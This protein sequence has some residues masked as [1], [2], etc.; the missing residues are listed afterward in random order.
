VG[1]QSA[2]LLP[3]CDRMGSLMYLATGAGL[4]FRFLEN[5]FTPSAKRARLSEQKSKHRDRQASWLYL[6]LLL[7]NLPLYGIDRDRRLDQLYHTAW[8]FK[9]GAPGEI[10]ALAQ[11]TDG[12]LWLGTATGLFR[13]DGIRFQRYKP[14]SEQAFP[15]RSVVSL[16]AVPD[17]GLWVGYRQGGVS[18]IKNETVTDYG[19]E[20]G[21]PSRAVLAFARDHQGTIWIAAGKDGL[22]RLDGSRWRKLGEDWGLTGHAYSVFVDHAGTLWVGTPTSVA[23]LVEGGHQFQIAAEHLLPF[24]HSFSEAPDG[25]LWMA[26]GGYGVRPVPLPGKNNGRAGPAVLVGSLAITF[27]NQGSLWITSAGNGIRRVPY[28]EG[29]HPPKIRGAS[30]WMF[31]NSEVEA[32]TQTNG[33]TSDYVHC[34]LQDREGNVWIGTS[35]GLD[36]FRQSPVVSVPLHPI[37]YGGALPIPSLNS[38]T[39]SAIAAGD[40]GALWAAGRGPEVLLK[41]QKDG[42]ATQL[43]DR[44]V[45]YVYRDPNGVI[46]LATWRSIFRLSDEGLDTIDSRPGAVTYNYLGALPAGQGM[47]LRQL[48]LPK[49]GGIAV[50]EQSRVKAITQ[51]QLGRLWISMESGTFRLER[52]SWTSLESLGGPQ[53]TA[54]AEF[55]DSEGRIWFGFSNAVATLDGDRVRIF[56]GKDGVQKGAVTSIQGQGTKIWIGGEFGLAFF[57]GS[58]F[59][60]VNPSDGSAFGG[61]SGIVADSQEG[62]WFSENRGIIHIREAQFRQSG[63]GK[64]KFESFGL[65]DGLTAQLRGSLSSPSAAQTT[66]GRIWFAT[67]NGLAW[68]NPT[69]IPRNT[70]P[71]PVLIQSVVADGR[72]YSTSTSFRLPARTANLQIAYTA[73]SLTIPERVRFRYKLE[74]EDKQWQDA[75]TR[76]E[77]FYTNLDPGTYHFRVIACNNDGAWNETGVSVDFSIAPTYYQTR[78]FRALCLAFF[79]VLTWLL[80]RLRVRSVEQ[81]YLERTRAAEALASQAAISLENTRLYRDIEDREGRIRRLVDA[82]IIGIVIWDLD[83]RLLDANDAFLRMVQYE[84]ED[85]Q[86]GLRW[87]DMTPPEWQEAHARYEAEE[88]KATG[89]MRPRE[90]EFFRKDS[91]RV[92]VLIG[93][94]CFEGQPNQ[95]VAYILDLSEQKRAE[96]ALRRSEA[97]LTE[98]QRLTHTGSCA[99]DGTSRETVYW[100]EEMFR[101]FGFDSQKGP[102]KWE[103]FLEKIHPDD[104]DKVALASDKTFRTKVKCDVEFRILKPDGTVRH[105]HGIGDPVLSSNGELIE[106][107]GTMVD[108]T[109]RKQADE[110]REKLRRLEDDL[111]HINRVST[112]G[113]LTASLA[114]EIKQPIGAAVTNAE[115]CLRLIDRREPDLPEAREAAFEMIKDARRAADVIEHVRSL[116]RKDSSSQ[117]RV[118]VNEVIREMVGILQKEADRHSVR[119]STDLTDGLTKVMADRVQLQQALMNLMLNGIEA[120]RD[121]TGELSIKS[122][123]GEDGQVLISVSDTGVG[124]PTENADQIFNAF[125]TTK[126]QGTGLGLAITRSIVE[127]HGGRIWATANSGP[128]A[129][130]RFTLP[131]TETTGR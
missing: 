131:I 108:V 6:L 115:V 126:S 66:D 72:R 65:L 23:Y 12:Y 98:A 43:R 49:A 124:L 128:G 71:P 97:Y 80:Y 33:L 52:S 109:E 116:F 55:T 113:E 13:S 87:F 82:N 79:I 112:M 88:L 39:T 69:R 101:L 46:W 14:Q 67:T 62:L 27:D 34:V 89:M 24:V 44:N 38:F 107:L 77:A 117:E 102:P 95:G 61:V 68:I 18:F 10:H 11:T 75:G 32:F 74:G 70:V 125:F 100:S 56:S 94:A 104:R 78:W 64:V 127:S 42:I 25:T 8:T 50:S 28:P 129:T 93:A 31:H 121:A 5:R 91:S 57:D 120:M 59:Q 99:I 118:D 1:I 4:A 73:A 37:S 7:L 90:K 130:F 85:L 47:L 30:A 26:E 60:P 54:T 81:R 48:D 86:A 3:G 40:Q 106:L 83:G 76:R 58:R 84:R 35:G 17:G 2:W 22:A 36:R 9:E 29:L 16:F 53:G 63:S 111:A 122:Q 20:E 114:H 15:Q 21:L 110:A 45:D 96:E 119:M 92:P 105:I 123:C 103:Q 19:E 41:I 51:D